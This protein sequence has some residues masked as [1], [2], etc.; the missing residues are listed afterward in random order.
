MFQ[1]NQHRN[2]PELTGRNQQT[3][4]DLGHPF[5]GLA[6][7]SLL[8][9]PSADVVSTFC[10][11]STFERNGCYIS[12]TYRELLY[13]FMRCWLNTW[14]WTLE[15]MC[16]ASQPW[17]G[18]DD[19]PAKP[20]PVFSSSVPNGDHTISFLLWLLHYF[21]L[22][23]LKQCIWFSTIPNYICLHRMERFY[24]YNSDLKVNRRTVNHCMHP[25]QLEHS[26]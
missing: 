11:S 6:G 25:Q 24:P 17:R 18:W 12:R 10:P 21:Q 20:V 5:W 22:W 3:A 23:R 8:T 26:I 2:L 14:V 13:S 4:S 19:I 9:S 16:N 7:H 1:V 15:A